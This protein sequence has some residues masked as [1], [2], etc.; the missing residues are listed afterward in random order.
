M[1]R[2]IMSQEN[3]T[4]QVNKGRRIQEQLELVL[5]SLIRLKMAVPKY[6]S[7]PMKIFCKIAISRLCMC[8]FIRSAAG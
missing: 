2:G 5:H 6:R 8:A 1:P 7:A 4:R 3:A